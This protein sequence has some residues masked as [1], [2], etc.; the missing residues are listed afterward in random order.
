MK[1]SAAKT[2]DVDQYSVVRATEVYG[3]KM[4]RREKEIGRPTD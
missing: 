1:R 3:Y 4:W 2:T